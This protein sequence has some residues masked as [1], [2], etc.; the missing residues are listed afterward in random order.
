MTALVAS[1]LA[2]ADERYHFG[3]VVRGRG[4]FA[5]GHLADDPVGR[6]LVVAASLGGRLEE[7]G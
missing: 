3:E 6:P 1:D 5:T 4:L 7:V 2:G